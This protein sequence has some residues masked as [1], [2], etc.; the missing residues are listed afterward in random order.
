MRK[1]CWAVCLVMLC[2]SCGERKNTKAGEGDMSNLLSVKKLQGVWLDDDTE[3]PVMKVKNDTV[4]LS[5]RTESSYRFA[6]SADTLF[7]RDA[8]HTVYFIKQLTDQNFCF[9]TSLG[10]TVRLHKAEDES[11]WVTS[12][13]SVLQPTEVLK[14]DSVIMY[15]GK[16]YRGYAYINPSTRKVVVPEVSGEGLIVDNVYYDNVIHICVFQGKEKICSKDITRDMFSEVVPANFLNH[17]ILSDMSFVGV[18]A[19]CYFYRAVIC[20]AS[21]H[22]ASCY[23]VKIGINREGALSFRLYQ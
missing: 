14:K 7:V 5:V 8:D 1:L 2:L 22:G 10:D 15:E 9:F 3:I 21:S 13:P 18:G 23:Y 16:R 11:V 12:S 19:D 17:S 6:V 4:I 20:S